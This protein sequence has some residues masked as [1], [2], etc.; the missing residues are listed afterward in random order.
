M[1]RTSAS[2]SSDGYGIMYS[3]EGTE[4]A[5][6]QSS[7]AARI[8]RS[9]MSKLRISRNPP[10]RSGPNTSMKS[11]ISITRLTPS[12]GAPQ[13]RVHKAG[14][15]GRLRRGERFRPWHPWIELIEDRTQ[16]SDTR[17]Q[18]ERIAVDRRAHKAHQFGI[19]SG[20]KSGRGID[21]NMA[22]RRSEDESAA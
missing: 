7:I 20:V 14:R 13:L 19:S 9:T 16:L 21:L 15:S 5:G 8:M 4:P 10:V 2:A 18:R 12:P 1:P 6:A 11:G 3:G 22:T 17:P